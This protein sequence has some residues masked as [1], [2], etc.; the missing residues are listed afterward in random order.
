MAPYLSGKEIDYI[1]GLLY[2]KKLAPGEIHT[3]LAAYRRRRGHEGP[4]LT[5]VRRAL[6][7]K[8]H[9]RAAPERRGRKRVFSR[10]QVQKMNHV[11]QNLL[12]RAQYFRS[13]C[14]AEVLRGASLQH[15]R[16]TITRVRELLYFSGNRCG[17]CLGTV[18]FSCKLLN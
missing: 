1:N 6:R 5:T 14:V 7:G 13:V 9:L 18:V 15:E 17:N 16:L 2:N 4:D 3:K 8:T 11:R 12:K 10:R